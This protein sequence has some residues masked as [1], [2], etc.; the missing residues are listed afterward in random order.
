MPPPAPNSRR[1]ALLT[2]RGVTVGIITAWPSVISTPSS[3]PCARCRSALLRLVCLFAPSTPPN[4]SCAWL[5][6][7]GSFPAPLRSRTWQCRRRC[8]S[9]P[10][11]AS[12]A[13]VPLA[14]W[15]F[16]PIGALGTTNR[17]CSSHSQNVTICDF[18]KCSI[19]AAVAKRFLA[20]TL[21]DT[22]SNISLR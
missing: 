20:V 19:L 1:N 3:Q 21:C 14:C 17:D 9:L 8:R 13:A 11:A 16:P 2:S 10:L 5:V 22:I 4:R 18:C 7:L 6:A 15:S 12:G